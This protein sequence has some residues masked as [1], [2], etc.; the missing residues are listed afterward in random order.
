MVEINVLI[1]E[2]EIVED[3]SIIKKIYVVNL[4]KLK[5]SID[6]YEEVEKVGI[7]KVEVDNDLIINLVLEN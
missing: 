5:V 7:V 4:L 2:E 3:I 1:E 6:D